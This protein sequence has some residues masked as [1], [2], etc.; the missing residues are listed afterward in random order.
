M[1]QLKEFCHLNVTYPLIATNEV[2]SITH[3]GRQVAL[4]I[5]LALHHL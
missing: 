5:T 1:L 2:S 3:H 4:Q